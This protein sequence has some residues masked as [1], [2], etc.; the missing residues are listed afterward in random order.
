MAGWLVGCLAGW[1]GLGWLG[2]LGWL[3]WL[4]GCWLDGLRV[5]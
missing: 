4:A 5:Y 1:A 3:D 2:W